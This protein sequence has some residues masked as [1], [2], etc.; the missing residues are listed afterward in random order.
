MLLSLT[1]S[2]RLK[3]LFNGKLEKSGWQTSY[4][5]AK[6]TALVGRYRKT[7]TMIKGSG[8]FHVRQCGRTIALQRRRRSPQCIPGKQMAYLWWQSATEKFDPIAWRS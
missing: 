1:H 5:M 7:N 4:D 6:W 8:S 2:N 3:A